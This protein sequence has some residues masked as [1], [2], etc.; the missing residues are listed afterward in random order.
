MNKRREMRKQEFKQHNQR[1]SQEK[2]KERLY[3]KL[4]DKWKI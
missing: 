4:M 1:L 2:A 3:A